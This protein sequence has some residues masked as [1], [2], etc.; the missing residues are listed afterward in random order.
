[1]K[2]ASPKFHRAR[3]LLLST[4]GYFLLGY[5]V[6]LSVLIIYRHPY[7]IDFTREREYTLSGDTLKRL[8]LLKENVRV[9]IPLM[10]QEGNPLHAIQA[11]VLLRARDLL[12]EYVARQPRLSI[13]A[14][15]D[16]RD[17]GDAESW[18]VICERYGLSAAQ[19]NRVIFIL[20]SGELRQVLT[21]EDLAVYDR[22]EGPHDPSP[23]QVREF[24]GEAAITSA[25]GRLVE[26]QKKRV[27]ALE[28]QR[29][30]LTTDKGPQGLTSFREELLANGYEVVSL[31]LALAPR[32]P[33]DCDLLLIAS[34]AAPFREEERAKLNEYLKGGGRLLAALGPAETGL[35]TLLDAW[36][37][38]VEKGHVYRQERRAGTALWV[39][40]F[41]VEE[42][43]AQ[44][45]ILEPLRGAPFGV[46]VSNVRAMGLADAAGLRGDFLLRTAEKPPAFIDRNQ[47]DRL[48]PEEKVD[49]VIVAGAVWRP[50]P[51]RPPPEY[52]HVDVRMVVLGDGSPLSNQWFPQVSHRD[53]L[54]NSVN[55][56]LGREERLAVGSSAWSERRLRWSGGI[57]SFLFWVPIFLVPGLVISVGG[58]VY[59]VRR[60]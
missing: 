52:R 59:F 54:L 37:I 3:G 51:E 53:L 31:K 23:P 48:D 8:S 12:R 19:Y 38:R 24:R 36:G 40:D 20:G 6:L 10:M 15:L 55:W 42:F 30:A 49:H 58:L 29:E 18:R 25:I 34:P 26:R 60:S 11:R 56:L 17:P 46:R 2:A 27:Y 45:P 5:I 14:Q 57:Q 41:F 43:N 47:N 13:E 33:E 50:R 35:E 1:M 7:R 4:A 32:I 44:H 39:P 21:P 9:L 28:D 22:P 16:L